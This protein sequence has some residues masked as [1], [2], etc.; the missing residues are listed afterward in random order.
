MLKQKVIKI[1]SE[2]VSSITLNSDVWGLPVN[3]EVLK[4]A[5]KLQ[6]DASRQGTRKTKTR[7]EVSGGGRKPWRQKGTGRARQGSIRSVQ[8]RG[9][10]V[11]FGVSPIKF[12]FK[13]NKKERMIA[14]KSALITK[15][16]N[17][18][19]TIV[20]KLSLSENKTREANELL[21]KLK[22]VGKTL[23]ITLEEDE[24]LALATN[25]LGNVGYILAEELNVYDLI[26]A[27]NIL[28][29]V[30]AIKKIEEMLK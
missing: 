10:G 27:N 19:I 15:L 11:A 13:I 29:E 9:G 16:T 3:E 23:L 4:K 14:L 30:D 20:D 6:R 25:N 18:E 8:W 5:L 21:N 26:N 17:D 7:A 28:V 12:D 22:L 2:E 24:N 1:N